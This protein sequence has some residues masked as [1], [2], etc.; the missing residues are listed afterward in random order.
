MTT[1]KLVVTIDTEEDEWGAF[2]LPRYGVSNI[3][4]L[5][6]LQ[7]LF[8]RFG[9]RP[10]YLVTQPVAETTSAIEVLGPILERRGCEIGAHCHPWNTPPFVEQRTPWNSLLCNL[11]TDLQF[12][13]LA[14]LK[15]SI[16]RNYGVTTTSFRAG[17]WGF[18]ASVAENLSRLG[19]LVESS[20][21]PYVS[22]SAYG[23]PSFDREYP[24]E[25]YRMSLQDIAMVEE[26]STLVEVPVTSGFTGLLGGMGY[27]AHRALSAAPLKWFRARGIAD[28]LDLFHTTWLCPEMHE[29]RPMIA[30]SDRVLAQGGTIL[31]LMFHSVT[32]T[33]GLTPF[34]RSVDDENRF[35]NRIR[36]YLEFCQREGIGSATLTE[37]SQQPVA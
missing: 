26:R 37:V 4:R 10:T 7:D 34:V 1:V 9:V 27:P 35:F 29:L 36:S 2:D 21:I 33:A 22:W 3:E 6:R 23:G 19:F 8:D 13:K 5:V 16:R 18:G 14:Y 28:R 32:L 25:R 30:L 31:N 20:I 17:R 12:Q 15:E 11:P 24:A